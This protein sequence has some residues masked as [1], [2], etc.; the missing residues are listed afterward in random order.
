MN[1]FDLAVG[2]LVVVVVVVF[3]VSNNVDFGGAVCFDVGVVVCLVV[4]FVSIVE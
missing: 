1:L 2:S 4:G 3:V